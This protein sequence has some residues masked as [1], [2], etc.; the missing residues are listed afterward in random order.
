MYYN[1]ITK[2]MGTLQTNQSDSRFSIKQML[3]GLGEYATY[4]LQLTNYNR[5]STNH[6]RSL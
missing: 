5:Y 2:G 1:R 6:L 4:F 3:L